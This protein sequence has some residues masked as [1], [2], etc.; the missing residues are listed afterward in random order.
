MHL[1]H[2]LPLLN[3]QQ[4]SQE[5][6][7][8]MAWQ[9][10]PSMCHSPYLSYSRPCGFRHQSGFH[11]LK[12][13]RYSNFL[14][15]IQNFLR[16]HWKISGWSWSLRASGM[17]D[18][19]LYFV[20]NSLGLA[21]GAMKLGEATHC[22]MTFLQ[23][24][25]CQ[26]IRN[27]YMC[28]AMLGWLP[29]VR[30]FMDQ[31]KLV[32]LFR[33]PQTPSLRQRLHHSNPQAAV[34]AFPIPS[35]QQRALGYRFRRVWYASTPGCESMLSLYYGWN[36]SS[37]LCSCQHASSRIAMATNTAVVVFASN[38]FA[39]WS[40]ARDDSFKWVLSRALL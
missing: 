34:Q 13:E 10:M 12:P 16:N 21:C 27:S 24:L 20:I 6:F 36:Q 9:L 11:T 3:R 2:K 15:R 28:C 35:L 7:I 31:K 23:E 26:L 39:N 5:A 22:L 14:I 40:A 4:E 30:C 19:I 37:A 8:G 29:F 17:V 1:R 32:L 25:C 33:R 18:R 38:V